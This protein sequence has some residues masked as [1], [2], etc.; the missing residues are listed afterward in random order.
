MTT[1]LVLGG[2]GF[3]GSH[4]VNALFTEGF[5]VKVFDKSMDK[6]FPEKVECIHGDFFNFKEWESVLKDVDFIFHNICTTIPKSSNEDII[7]D[8]ETNVIGNVR[9]LQEVVKSETEKFI[10]SSSGGTIYGEPLV[11]PIPESH[12]TNPIS[13]YGISKLAFEKYL[14]FFNNE[15]G[16]DFISLRYSNVFGEGQNPKGMVGAVI[17]FLELLR[18]KKPITIYGNGNSVRDFIYID[19]VIKAN[20]LTAR[21]KSKHKIFN[22]GT[23]IGTSVETL[24]ETIFRIT[25]KQTEVFFTGMRSGDV[26]TN[27]L[28][29]SLIRR[30]FDW[31]PKVNLE[32]GI[33]RIWT[34]MQNDINPI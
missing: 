26:S 27:I 20:L 9:F 23:G 22:V 13:S 11:L 3:I 18:E 7:Y 5:N 21:K 15:Y 24:I 1:C 10:F 34:Y 28:D 32:D 19:D 17:I 4:I 6:K 16:L 2:K 31:D 33:L 8:I 29:I 12:P 30:E 25:H 14:N